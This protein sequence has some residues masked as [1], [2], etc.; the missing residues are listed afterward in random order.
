VT[1]FYYMVH[2]LIIGPTGDTD[3]I[4]LG[5]NDSIASERLVAGASPF[6]DPCFLDV[7]VRVWQGEDQ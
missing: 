5:E 1:R 3:S 7:V 6:D 4:I 2:R